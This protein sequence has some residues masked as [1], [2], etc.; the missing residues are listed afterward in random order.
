MLSSNFIAGNSLTL[1]TAPRNKNGRNVSN[2]SYVKDLLDYRLVD[3]HFGSNL[4]GDLQEALL[5]R[6]F[7][8]VFGDQLESLDH[9]LELLNFDLKDRTLRLVDLLDPLQ[10]DFGALVYQGVGQVDL[11]HQLDVPSL[12]ADSL[13]DLFLGLK[14]VSVAFVN[15]C[16]G[17]DDGLFLHRVLLIDFSD[18]GVLIFLHDILPGGVVVLFFFC[19]VDCFLN[20]DLVVLVNIRYLL[21]GLRWV[22]LFLGHTTH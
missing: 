20:S 5:K 10:I 9:F 19:G 4:L 18:L 17:N 16:L 7:L 21:D 13:Q 22:V 8:L 12:L 2:F 14:D 1:G 3:T 15:L 11:L 6:H